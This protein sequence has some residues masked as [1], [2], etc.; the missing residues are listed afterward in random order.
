MPVFEPYPFGSPRE[1]DA[2]AFRR[3]G[4][5]TFHPAKDKNV[6]QFQF[7]VKNVVRKFFQEGPG[8]TLV[9]KTWLA[10]AP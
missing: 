6:A 7:P 8:P 9:P 10:P 1:A 5:G 2:A 4:S 3:A